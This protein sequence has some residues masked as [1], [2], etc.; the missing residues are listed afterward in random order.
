MTDPFD[1]TANLQH[2]VNAYVDA[3]FGT[4]PPD[5][6]MLNLIEEVGEL[7]RAL[8]K[9]RQGIRGTTEEWTAEIRKEIGDTLISLFVLAEQ[10]GVNALSVAVERWSAVRQRDWSTDRIQHGITPS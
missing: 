8:I 5:V 1:F 4:T 6:Q 9:R 10:E 3:N 7:S 2:D